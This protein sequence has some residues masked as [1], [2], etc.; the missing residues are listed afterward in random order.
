MTS[1]SESDLTSWLSDEEVRIKDTLQGSNGAYENAILNGLLEQYTSRLV[2]RED[3]LVTANI[4]E[5][6]SHMP[7]SFTEAPALCTKNVHLST[8]SVSYR[9][10]GSLKRTR[11]DRWI[12]LMHTSTNDGPVLEVKDA[13]KI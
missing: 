4:K 6:P 1:R 11:P 12:D 7:G 5:A 8:Y 13:P 10:N 9:M 3:G 2:I